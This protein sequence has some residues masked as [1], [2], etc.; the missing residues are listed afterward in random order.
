VQDMRILL[1]H[2]LKSGKG[3]TEV[4]AVNFSHNGDVLAAA[5]ATGE[6]AVYGTS[7]TARLAKFLQDDGYGVFDFRVLAFSED[8]SRLAMGG[9]SCATVAVHWLTAQRPRRF[10]IP[11][12]NADLTSAAVSARHVAL[13][14]GSRVVVQLHDGT[15]V[16]DI[17]TGDP[18]CCNFQKCPVNLHPSRD[19]VAVMV[20]NKFV[21]VYSF[22]VP[23]GKLVFRKEDGFG[24]AC[25]VR[26]SP[27]GL[28]LLVPGMGGG[29]CVFSAQTGKTIHA[30][31][32]K[33]DYEFVNDV[34]VDPL[35]KR[36]VCT[37]LGGNGGLNLTDPETGTKVGS[38]DQDLAE[39]HG[40]KFNW[41]VVDAASHRLAYLRIDGKGHGAVVVRSLGE[42]GECLASFENEPDAEA[43][44]GPKGFNGDWLLCCEYEVEETA[45]SDVTLVDVQNSGAEVELNKLLLAILGT[46]YTAHSS[47]GWVPGTEH[48][49]IHA[50]VGSELVF[51]DLQHV[52]LMQADGCLHAQ[53]LMDL[54]GDDSGGFYHPDTIDAIVKRFPDCINVP[55]RTRSSGGTLQD[56]SIGDTVLHY[57]ARK[58]RTE[59][60][61]RWLPSDGGIYTPVSSGSRKYMRGVEQHDCEH[62]TA[63]HEAI[64]RSNKDMV[65]HLL[66]T[67]NKSMN[68]VT[69][70]LV[71][72]AMSLMAYKMPYLVADALKLLDDRLVQTEFTI[73]TRIRTQS[74]AFVIGRDELVDRYTSGP[75]DQPNDHAIERAASTDLTAGGPTASRA[76]GVD[77][78]PASGTAILP[79]EP[80]NQQ[81]NRTA[82]VDIKVVQIANL[83]GPRDCSPFEA[84]VENCDFAVCESTIMKAAIDFKW[85]RIQWYVYAELGCFLV[86]L[87]VASVA[88]FDSAWTAHNV[89]DG[90]LS[91]AD[92][93]TPKTLFVLMVVLEALLLVLEM[94]ELIVHRSKWLKLYNCI[95]VASILLLLTP[96]AI[97]LVARELHAGDIVWQRLSTALL[98]SAGSVGLGLKWLGLLGY[99]DSFQC[100]PPVHMCSACRTCLLLVLLGVL[101]SDFSKTFK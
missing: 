72:D 12:S 30:L 45:S 78:W 75:G 79:V 68:F 7:S 31:T 22:E 65:L 89:A 97:Y 6:V 24:Y 80:P 44:V 101:S 81:G 52:E 1:A 91:D 18:I 35:T 34:I 83:I 10:A 55:K 25:G 13:V 86:S 88:M 60:A 58:R 63:L 84:I 3:K 41:P 59:A 95:N 53:L 39:N 74:E 2:P 85:Q 82:Q 90:S 16:A 14:C 87:F 99:L 64:D 36:I 15:G 61:K 92:S 23:E 49:T 19:H 57:C 38:F 29:A 51:V 47:V 48:P 21:E 73:E 93:S 77:P 50:S 4:V 37:N 9:G 98:Q 28:Q 17:D 46:G 5:W 62:W 96:A 42:E 20:S 26:Y 8:D 69:A 94:V 70:E 43:P 11:D 54:C 56:A 71:A 67:L 40:A 76:S 100:K 32:S 33:P 27:D 66:G